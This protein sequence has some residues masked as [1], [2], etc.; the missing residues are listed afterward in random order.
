M[1]GILELQSGKG[2]GTS[3]K[4]FNV[5]HSMQWHMCTCTCTCA[6]ETCTVHVLYMYC[7]CTVHVHSLVIDR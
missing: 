6:I 3:P 7:T 1:R 5:N 4:K 2:L